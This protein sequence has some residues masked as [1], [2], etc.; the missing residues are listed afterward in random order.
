MKLFLILCQFLLEAFAGVARLSADLTPEPGQVC[1][2]FSRRRLALAAGGRAEA[3]GGSARGLTEAQ[4]HRR[5]R[6]CEAGP[7]RTGS[8]GRWG[9]RGTAA[10]PCRAVRPVRGRARP[11]ARPAAASIPARG[12]R[13]ERPD[14]RRPARAPARRP[15]ADGRGACPREPGRS[16]GAS[17]RRRR[18]VEP[19]GAAG[20]AGATGPES[21]GPREAAAAQRGRRGRSSAVQSGDAGQAVLVPDTLLWASRVGRRHCLPMQTHRGPW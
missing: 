14:P 3:A 11:R 19:R 21:P 2:G 18:R 6:E 8:S 12:P 20:R 15:P 1:R 4:A 17:W 13:S 5:V 16:P 7:A 10:P 9:A